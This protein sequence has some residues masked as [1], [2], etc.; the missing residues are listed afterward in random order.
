MARERCRD[1]TR[2]EADTAHAESV[3]ATIVLCGTESIRA[4]HYNKGSDMHRA[5]G[6][7]VA[8]DVRSEAASAWTANQVGPR[9]R[10]MA[11]RLA[12]APSSISNHHEAHG[13]ALPL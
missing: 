13:C 3:H 1:Y 6:D 7:I 2:R 10:L 9:A 5:L 8:Q 11:S 12:N 4:S